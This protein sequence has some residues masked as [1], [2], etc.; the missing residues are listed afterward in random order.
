MAKKTK[1]LTP[2]IGAAIT[3][4][5]FSNDLDFAVGFSCTDLVEPITDPVLSPML[6]VGTFVD[7]AAHL[8]PAIQNYL[9]V[10][11]KYVSGLKL[12]DNSN[13]TYANDD[14]H[15]EAISGRLS[16]TVKSGGKQTNNPKPKATYKVL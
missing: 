15:A 5:A 7:V 16:I 12:V 8:H 3:P 9:V 11:G 6:V 13:R 1:T 10:T 4:L 2:T 14:I